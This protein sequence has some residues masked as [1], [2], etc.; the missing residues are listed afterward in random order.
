MSRLTYNQ[1]RAFVIALIVFAS[2][3]AILTALP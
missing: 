3:V 2:I 1:R